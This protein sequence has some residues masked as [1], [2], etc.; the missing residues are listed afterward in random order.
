MK[1]IIIILALI[2]GVILLIIGKKTQIHKYS[3]NIG[4]LIIVACLCMVMPDFI[5]GFID[6]ISGK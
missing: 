3:K 5:K 6:G 4:I 1:A 2:I